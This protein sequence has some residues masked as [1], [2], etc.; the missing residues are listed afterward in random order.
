MNAGQGAFF[1]LLDEFADSKSIKE[2]HQ[3]WHNYV[4][5]ILNL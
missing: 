5:S 3:T 4:K 2:E 1:K